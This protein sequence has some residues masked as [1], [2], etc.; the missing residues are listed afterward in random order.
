MSRKTHLSQKQAHK[1][2]VKCSTIIKK[3]QISS[4]HPNQ[5]HQVGTILD[6]LGQLLE[7]DTHALFTVYHG[8]CCR[9]TQSGEC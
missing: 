3:K 7:A 6:G 1:K 9:Y 4:S 8:L 2:K 5:T